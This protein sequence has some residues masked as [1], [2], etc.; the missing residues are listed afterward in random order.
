MHCDY[1][2]REFWRSNHATDDVTRACRSAKAVR[3]WANAYNASSEQTLSE[4]QPVELTL[5][6]IDQLSFLLTTAKEGLHELVKESCTSEAIDLPFEAYQK[7]RCQA[8]KC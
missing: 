3:R 7:P 2:A 5:I 1:E 6:G 8:C 4:T